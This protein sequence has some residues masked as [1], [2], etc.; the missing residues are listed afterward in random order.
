MISV[1]R[2]GFVPS[3]LEKGCLVKISGDKTGERGFPLVEFTCVQIVLSSINLQ[4]G[5]RCPFTVLGHLDFAGIFWKNLSL[6][7]TVFK[8][9]G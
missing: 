8:G 1:K 4:G 7:L 6:H 9:G 2:L 5:P 3:W